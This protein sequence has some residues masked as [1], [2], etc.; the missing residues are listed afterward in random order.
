MPRDIA[1]AFG[2][3][4]GFWLALWLSPLSV[5]ATEAMSSPVAMRGR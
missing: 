1:Q 2:F 5:K 3:L 4:L